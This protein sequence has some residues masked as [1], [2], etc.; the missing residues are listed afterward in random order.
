MGLANSKPVRF[1]QAKSAPKDSKLGKTRK[2][3]EWTL[4]NL[5]DA[6][7]VLG[8]IK[9]DVKSLVTHSEF[10]LELYSSLSTDV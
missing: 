9:E 1:N 4:G 7:Y 2:L 8:H 10:F 5:I 3:H 6:S